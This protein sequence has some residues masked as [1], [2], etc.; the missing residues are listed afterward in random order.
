MPLWLALDLY[1]KDKCAI[2]PPDWLDEITIKE[3]VEAEKRAQNLEIAKGLENL[4]LIKL[5]DFHF[6]EISSKM[7][8]VAEIQNAQIVKTCVEDLYILWRNKILKEMKD[9][10]T[11][12][13]KFKKLKNITSLELGALRG[14][15][16]KAY[17]A[18]F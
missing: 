13:E 5:P 14:V 15:Y 9:I 3:L 16:S 10:K 6:F 12:K 1:S 17:E 18:A 11:E 8:K 7:L 2:I 4:N